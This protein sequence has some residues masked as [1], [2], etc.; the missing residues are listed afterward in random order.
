[1]SAHLESGENLVC[2]LLKRKNSG[3]LG[4]FTANKGK[5]AQ[6]RSTAV[7][8]IEIAV[9]GLVLRLPVPQQRNSFVYATA[10]FLYFLVLAFLILWKLN[11]LLLHSEAT[12]LST[13]MEPVTQLDSR[14]R[15]S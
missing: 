4:F 13:Q 1:M 5:F 6:W 8:L 7:T 2:L 14:E 12:M 9:V 15:S 3:H 11:S 10:S